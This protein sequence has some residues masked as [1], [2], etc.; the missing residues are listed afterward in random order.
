MI[1]KISIFTFSFYP[2]RKAMLDYLNKVF[3]K[4]VHIFLFT[5]KGHKEKYKDNY[6]RITIVET[7][8]SRLTSFFEFRRFCKKNKIER[9]IN[10][11]ILPYEGFVMFFSTIFS[12]TDFITFNLGNPIEVMRVGKIKDRLIGSIEAFSL[13]FLSVF[14]KKMIL[15]SKS[16]ETYAKKSY[17]FRNRVDYLPPTIPT[18]FFKL[19]SKDQVR[20]KLGIKNNEKVVLF[21][22]RIHYLKGSDIL[23]SLIKNNPDK[24]FILI[25]KIKDEN[26]NKEK[27][28]NLVLI[29]EKTHE[30]LVDYYNAADICVFPSRL[31]GLALVPREAMACGTPAIILNTL[32]SK[33]IEAA[34][35]ADNY[36]DFNKNLNDFFNLSNDK[37]KSLSKKSRDYIIKEYDDLVHK[38]NYI[39]KLLN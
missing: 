31:E 22:G 32:T 34:I 5:T 3:P 35:K 4:D 39:D 30:E 8:C 11:G 20:K 2:N 26:Y 14:S 25:G 10:I 38:G 12:K 15:C 19:K 23:L 17:L 27:F 28:A 21:V 9:V 1:K 37:R 36:S 24:K 6:K 13:L 7:D 29:P 18:E 16:L 33:S